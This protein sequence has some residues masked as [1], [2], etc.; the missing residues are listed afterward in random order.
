MANTPTVFNYFSIPKYPYIQF[1]KPSQFSSKLY[2]WAVDS[3][4]Q[5]TAYSEIL[6]QLI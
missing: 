5:W 1:K 3:K 6:C 4:M 2:K